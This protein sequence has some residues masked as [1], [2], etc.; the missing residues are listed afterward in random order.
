MAGSPAATGGSSETVQLL[1]EEALLAMPATDE[2]L[3]DAARAAA[4]GVGLSCGI[5]YLARY[6]AVTVAG[7]DARANAVDEIQYSGGT[8]PCLEALHTGV[9][10]RVHDLAVET[11][12]GGYR[13]LALQA[14]VRA[15][16]SLPLLVADQAIGALNVY[17]TERGPLPADQEAAALLSA[18]Q[19]TGM[20]AT[21]R[22][23]AANLVKDPEAAHLFQARHQLDI[24]TGIL[25][26]QHGCTADQAR[27]LLSDRANDKGIPIADVVAHTIAAS[28][29]GSGSTS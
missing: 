28:G 23:L 25:M 22:R 13:D 9:V 4:H 20:L 12:W 3:H 6:G 11:R 5:T 27:D 19:V 18:N 24:A 7:S 17:S 10:V 14:G 15:S 8:G 2:L 29:L 1:A 26:S 16:L 21:V